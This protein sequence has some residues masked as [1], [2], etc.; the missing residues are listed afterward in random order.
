ML[1][2]KLPSSHSTSPI[3]AIFLCLVA[4]VML[5]ACSVQPEK[6]PLPPT[7]TPSTPTEP[8]IKPSQKIDSG[9][10]QRQKNKETILAPCVYDSTKGV[11]E[12]TAISPEQ[13]T[14]KFYPGD[15]YF[16]MPISAINHLNPSLGLELKAIVRAPL[17]GP[18]NAAEFELLST[19][20]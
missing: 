7:N 10:E 19:V 17:S 11:A 15:Q 20:E 5:S 9:T 3:F 16:K 13:V 2:K 1:A 18:C 6:I 4:L 12:I 8:T 14:F